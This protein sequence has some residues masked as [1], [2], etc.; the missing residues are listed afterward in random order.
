MQ[1]K[2]NNA[3]EEDISLSPVCLSWSNRH[4]VGIVLP[5]H[6]PPLSVHSLFFFFGGREKQQK[7]RRSS[8]DSTQSVKEQT[9]DVL[10]KENTNV[11]R[12]TFKSSKI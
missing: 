6:L 11:H 5:L 12:R 8:R 2:K 9:I 10:L 4:R 7:L 1:W 3:V